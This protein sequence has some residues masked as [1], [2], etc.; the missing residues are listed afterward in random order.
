MPLSV[1]VILNGGVEGYDV[2][3]AGRA[4]EG[5]EGVPN[6][7]LVSIYSLYAVALLGC[8]RSTFWI[9]LNSPSDS[10]EN[11]DNTFLRLAEF[12]ALLIWKT[13]ISSIVQ[14]TLRVIQNPLIQHHWTE[15]PVRDYLHPPWI[16]F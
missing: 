9:Q 6:L 7:L 16:S 15:A 14:G 13:S 8:D 12:T 3:G 11:S 2:S 10:A 4:Y 5:L 1:R